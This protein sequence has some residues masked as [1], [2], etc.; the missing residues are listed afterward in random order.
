M[1]VDEWADH[2]HDDDVNDA[3]P[4]SAADGWDEPAP[5]LLFPNLIAFVT[6]WLVPMYRRSMENREYAWCPQWWQHPEAVYACPHS[7]VGSRSNV[8]NLDQR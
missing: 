8:S 5:E 7:G 6:E 1:S 3:G 2:R 4:A